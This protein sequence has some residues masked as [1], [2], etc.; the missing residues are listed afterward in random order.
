MQLS[1]CPTSLSSPQGRPIAA[2]LESKAITCSERRHVYDD[3]GL[4]AY[5]T[6]CKVR[7][8]RACLPKPP[9]D[10]GVLM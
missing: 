1:V 2:K 8:S 9:V 4:R 7:R 10:K 3:Y 5:L 6:G